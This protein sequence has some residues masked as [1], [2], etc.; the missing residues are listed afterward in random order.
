[1]NHAPPA[2]ALRD[3]HFVPV[4]NVENLRIQPSGTG[5]RGGAKLVD[6][7]NSKAGGEVELNCMGVWRTQDVNCFSSFSILIL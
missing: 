4:Q 6:I 1:M 5:D 2:L 7:E 3:A